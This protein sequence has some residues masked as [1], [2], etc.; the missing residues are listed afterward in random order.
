MKVIK[1]L[2]VGVI[3]AIVAYV[4]NMLSSMA[5][6][7]FY[8][9]PAYFGVWSS[10]MMPTAGP[11]PTSFMMFSLLFGFIGWVLFAG[12]YEILKKAVPGKD[13]LYRGMNY[14]LLVFLVGAVPGYLAIVLLINLPA[15]LITVWAIESLVAYLINGVI[16]AKMLK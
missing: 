9:D 14:G 4:L 7:G 6:M 13:M 2:P 10:L 8:M 16:T 15:A 11:P 3:C 1:L 12:V 5:T